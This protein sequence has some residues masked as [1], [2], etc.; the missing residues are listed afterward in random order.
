MILTRLKYQGH[1]EFI[2]GSLWR[3]YTKC[4][5]VIINKDEYLL[6]SNYSMTTSH[7]VSG[8]YLLE[9]KI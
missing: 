1:P 6:S 5:I 2:S 3:T 7:Q 9:Q 8:I 4:L